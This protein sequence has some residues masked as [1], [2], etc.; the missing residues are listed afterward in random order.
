M[1]F[2]M[3][4]SVEVSYFFFDFSHFLLTKLEEFSLSLRQYFV[5]CFLNHEITKNFFLFKFITASGFYKRQKRTRDWLPL[6]T[7]KFYRSLQTIGTDFSVMLQLF[8]NRSRRDLK[9]KVKNF[10]ILR[11]KKLIFNYGINY[12]IIWKMIILVQKRRK[13]QYGLNK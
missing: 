12:K 2:T 13:T 4:N 10:K 5:I 1:L 7:L 6:E 11:N 3:M 9:L 8:P